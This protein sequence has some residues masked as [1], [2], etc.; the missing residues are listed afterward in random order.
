MGCCDLA[1]FFEHRKYERVS[2]LLYHSQVRAGG[3][4]RF[5][6][7]C[8]VSVFK[9]MFIADLPQ[10][11]KGTVCYRP[12]GDTGEFDDCAFGNDGFV[13]IV[14]VRADNGMSSGLWMDEI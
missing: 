6:T 7:Y 11:W 12:Y 13:V 8:H 4:R 3:A 14:T 1:M 10:R 2:E 9:P 5:D